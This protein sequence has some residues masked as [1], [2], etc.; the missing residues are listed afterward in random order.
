MDF[1]KF[2]KTPDFVLQDITEKEPQLRSEMLGETE[3]S[4]PLSPK[5]GNSP[6]LFD[7]IRND[8]QQAQPNRVNIGGILDGKTVVDMADHILPAISVLAAAKIF[9]YNIYKSQLQ[10][11]AKEKATLAP[12]VDN[13]L[14]TMNIAVTSPVGALMIA[15]GAIYAGKFIEVLPTA[16][17]IR[18]PPSPP[19]SPKGGIREEKKEAENTDVT[20]LGDGGKTPLQKAESNFKSKFT[21]RGKNGLPLGKG[22]RGSYKK[23]K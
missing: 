14:R 10:F 13:V 19:P 2:E 22:S 12:L 11:T 9:G 6:D 7:T 1:E 5:G 15:L 23:T 20:P 8:Y 4:A 21:G 3:D 18:Q 17:K 16:E